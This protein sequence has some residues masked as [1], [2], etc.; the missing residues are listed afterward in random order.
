MGI[1]VH[2]RLIACGQI[3]QLGRQLENEGNY[4]MDLR[5]EPVGQELYEKL[6]AL[7][8]VKRIEQ[9]AGGLMRIESSRDI[10]RDA[11][12]LVMETGSVLTELHQRGGDLDEIY[13]RYFEKA[14][15]NDERAGVG[16]TGGKLRSL[17]HK[18]RASGQ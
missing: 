11:V 9:D 5:A 8:G 17:F 1:F 7:S 18:E 2:G 3:D 13:H 16:K 14:G 10:R 4:S 15:E 12:S 6:S